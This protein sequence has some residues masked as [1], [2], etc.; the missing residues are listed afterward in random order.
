[1]ADDRVVAGDAIDLTVTV[2]NTGTDPLTGLT[3]DTPEVPE[4]TGI[5]PDLDPGEHHDVACQH[6]T[7]D[8]D[9]IGTFTSTASADAAEVTGPIPAEPVDVEVLDPTAAAL[10]VSQ[11]TDQDVVVVGD[12]IDLDVTVHNTGA[13]ALTDVVVTTPEAPGCTGE[14][15]DLDPDESETVECTVTTVDP[16]DLGTWTS[17]ASADAAEL[18]APVDAAT[19]EVTV[20]APDRSGPTVSVT[21]PVNGA[22]YNQGQVVLA[23]YACTD[24]S[25]FAECL[26]TVPDGQPIDTSTPGT[27]VFNVVTTDLAGQTPP[28]EVRT[29]T[30]AARRPDGRI[31]QGATGPMVG[32]NVVNTTGAGQ[33][34]TVQQVR[35]GQATF[36]VTLQNDG[37]MP[38]QL[39]VR[40]QPG[41]TNYAVRYATGG[42]DI[43][44]A[45]RTGAYVTPTPLAVGA[46]R[47]IK[48]VVTVG[49]HAPV[50]SQV[51]RLV[52]ITSTSDPTRKDVVRFVVKRR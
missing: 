39:R 35:G 12:D 33:T 21:T 47:T 42:Q 4:C 9:D 14:V 15:E 23:D 51:D 38:E 36:F 1:V 28:S 40:G 49:L 6:L 37:T 18:L 26:G 34:R 25:G 22:V 2:T 27:K 50:G 7:V 48:V 8:P 20:I 10:E 32:E 11:A 52:T 41:T 17:T 31:R 3:V 45:V 44:A 46:V 43:T 5:V 13:V 19:A 16:D 29:Y 30:V 24:D